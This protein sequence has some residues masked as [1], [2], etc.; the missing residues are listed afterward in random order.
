MIRRY[1]IYN[2]RNHKEYLEVPVTIVVQVIFNETFKSEHVLVVQIHEDDRLP[3]EFVW[4]RK[5]LYPTEDDLIGAA[6]GI[7]RLQVVYKLNTTDL[8]EGNLQGV[9]G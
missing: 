6:V 8:A 3:T 2:E 4:D 9:F 1:C 7:G 5:L